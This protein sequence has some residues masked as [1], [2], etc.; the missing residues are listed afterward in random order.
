M[1]SFWSKVTPI[2]D[3]LGASVNENVQHVV[4]NMCIC[5]IVCNIS[6]IKLIVF[7]WNCEY[8]VANE[9]NHWSGND[10]SLFK[11]LTPI[12]YGLGYHAIDICLS[13]SHIIKIVDLISSIHRN[14]LLFSSLWKMGKYGN[15]IFMLST[16]VTINVK[17]VGLIRTVSHTNVY[18]NTTLEYR[19]LLLTGSEMWKGSLGINGSNPIPGV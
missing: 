19:Y 4:V 13:C 17:C 10:V 14:T 8:I 15:L 9:E 1:A 18:Q 6:F 16:L 11:L 3:M 12:M 5:Q 2:T 7:R